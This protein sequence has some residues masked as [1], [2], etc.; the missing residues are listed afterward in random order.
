M[1]ISTNVKKALRA[2]G[3]NLDD[4]AAA[5]NVSRMQVYRYLNG[6]ITLSNLQRL[7]AALNIPPSKLLEE[8]PEADN[9]GP[10]PAGLPAVL[11]IICPS[12]RKQIY[13]NVRQTRNPGPGPDGC[14][15]TPGAIP[16]ESDPDP[17]T[18]SDNRPHL[19]ENHD[20]GN[21]ENT[22]F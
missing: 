3:K 17:E 4:L 7:A 10:I 14:P 15:Q 6:N 1:D 12:C 20:P 13:L 22:L 18:A 21:Q 16:P 19:K 11:S 8:G 5:L 9:P 2:Q